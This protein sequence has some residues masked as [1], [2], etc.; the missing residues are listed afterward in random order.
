L[1]FD[2]VIM[3]CWSGDKMT[4]VTTCHEQRA[5]VHALDSALQKAISDLSPE[6]ATVH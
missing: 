4:M 1:D 2:N 6:G 3:V 5:V